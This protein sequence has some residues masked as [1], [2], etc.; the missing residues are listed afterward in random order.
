MKVNP[1]RQNTRTKM[2][3]VI[4]CSILNRFYEPEAEFTGFYVGTWSNICSHDK[5]SLNLF[6]LVFFGFMTFFKMERLLTGLQKTSPYINWW[7]GLFWSNSVQ[8]Q[9]FFGPMDWTLEH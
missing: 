5:I 4:S 1:I 9:S 2:D 6:K 8:F 7:S 3:L